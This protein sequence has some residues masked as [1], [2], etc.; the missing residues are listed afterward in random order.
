MKPDYL[1]AWMRTERGPQEEWLHRI[2]KADDPFCP[3]DHTTIQSGAHITFSC[4]LHTQARHRLTS[5]RQSW[6]ELDSP[7][8]IKR[9]RLDQDRPQR[10][11][12]RSHQLLRVSLIPYTV[13]SLSLSPRFIFLFCVALRLSRLSRLF[14]FCF[15][16]LCLVTRPCSPLLDIS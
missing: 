16:L 10:T 3:C 5:N 4:A 8:W 12:G 7:R 1:D 6:E 14:S 11:R 9:S 13:T 2:G 15:I